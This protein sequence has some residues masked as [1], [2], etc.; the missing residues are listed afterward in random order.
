M[1]RY[2]WYLRSESDLYEPLC[3]CVLEG[4]A[5]GLQ[6]EV[7]LHV[8]AP[9]ITAFMEWVISAAEQKGIRRLYFLARDGWLWMR[10]AE[11]VQK[12]RHSGDPLSHADTT[13]DPDEA[14]ELR[15]LCVSR[16]TLYAGTEDL[17]S[18]LRQ[19]GL[20]ED[21][22][23]GIVDSGWIGTTK[24]SL[25][26]L[27]G[28]TIDGFYFGMYE[29]PSGTD[30]KTYHCFYLRP[31]RDIERKAHF[32]I[33]LF[34]AVNSSPEGMTVGYER[35]DKII[36][37]C[38]DENPNGAWMRR[39]SVMLER[40]LSHYEEKSSPWKL[41]RGGLKKRI[42]ALD[43]SL[44]L[45]MGRPTREE[46][47]AFGRMLFDEGVEGTHLR[48]LALRWDLQEI[49]NQRLFRRISNKLHGREAFR[50]SGWQEGSIV[51]S[52]EESDQKRAL[53]DERIYQRAR[54]VAKAI[55]RMV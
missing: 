39:F 6:E 33:C 52:T 7:F 51:L 38:M 53:R 48:T 34:E 20:F 29:V 16:K 23:Y 37:V 10:A 44:S 28:K 27:I 49:E 11:C 17:R 42:R 1:D 21:V 19:E 4:C 22:P 36:P 55:R 8:F 30:P 13:S 40:Y 15:Y 46:A 5:E 43:R 47:K 14:M 25:E 50:E 2:R 32:S 24:Q 18:Y 3:A 12:R 41:R 26:K 54:Q 9:A 35:R 31:Y 45:L